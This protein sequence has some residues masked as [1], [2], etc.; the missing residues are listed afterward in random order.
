MAS[1][2]GREVVRLAFGTRYTV[3]EGWPHIW[4]TNIVTLIDSNGQ[5]FQ[6]V[7]EGRPVTDSKTD[8]PDLDH[9]GYIT[10]QIHRGVRRQRQM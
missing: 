3:Q 7:T 6:R 1:L 2:S 9:M 10:R 8:E 4:R 5:H